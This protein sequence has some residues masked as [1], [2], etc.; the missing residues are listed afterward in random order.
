MP[1]INT[2][3]KQ[4]GDTYLTIADYHN[5]KGVW[6]RIVKNGELLEPAF[7]SLAQYGSFDKAKKAAIRYRNQLVRKYNVIPRKLRAAGPYANYREADPRNFTGV[8]GVGLQLH[9]K[10]GYYH[11][12]WKAQWYRKDTGL[13]TRSLS[14]AKHGYKTAFRTL[15]K[16]RYEETGQD[17]KR[18]PSAPDRKAMAAHLRERLGPQWRS[19]ISPK[20]DQW[21]DGR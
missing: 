12:T 10:D 9:E 1:S 13:K 21:W 3:I 18:L 14:I 8:V 20:W 4:L 2:V 7:F 5:S 6:V 16:K 15:V 11:A 19:L 17:V